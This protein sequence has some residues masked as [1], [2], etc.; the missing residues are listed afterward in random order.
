MPVPAAH[1]ILPAGRGGKGVLVARFGP[2]GAHDT[3]FGTTAGFA[4]LSSG[5]VSGIARDATGNVYVAAES[6]VY[7]LSA[8][9]VPDVSWNGGSG[10]SVQSPNASEWF[11]SEGLA[12]DASGRPIVA[13]EGGGTGANTLVVARMTTAGVQD[14]SFGTANGLPARTAYQRADATARAVAVLA[15]G[16]ILVAGNTDAGV[17]FLLRLDANGALDASFA[18]G[19]FQSYDTL[20][21]LASMAVQV[22]GKIVL[23]CGSSVVRVDASGALDATFG[24]AGVS[25]ALEAIGFA[26]VAIRVRADGAIMIVS[27]EKAGDKDTIGVAR[28]SAS[29]VLERHATPAFPVPVRASDLVVQKTGATVAGGYAVG[30]VT[31]RD[32]ALARFTP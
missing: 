30:L 5:G 11:L 10:K 17:P 6:Q 4:E 14:T 31:D 3:T 9:G 13:G 32:F 20:S 18:G 8:Q 19:G 7:R 27:R 23:G 2:N 29:G 15:D 12:I 25:N 16:K 28:L 1:S 26:A 21:Y 24:Q 22:D